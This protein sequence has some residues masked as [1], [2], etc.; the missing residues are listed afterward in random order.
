M[1]IR[2]GARRLRLD[3]SVQR[4]PGLVL[5]GSPISLFRITEAADELIDRIE[6]GESVP[7][8]RLTAALLDGGAVHPVAEPPATAHTI[9]DVTIVVPTLGP[10]EHRPRGDR[11]VIVDDGSVPPIAESTVRLDENRGPAAAR[12]AG[13]EQVHTALVAFVDADVRTP[14][15]WIERLLPHLDD[16]QVAIVA[17]R[18]RS[19]DG[20]SGVARYESSGSALDLGAE[21]GRVRAGNRV[22][23]LPAAALLCRVDALRSVEGFDESLRFGEDVDLVWRLDEAGWRVRYEPAVVVEHEPRA[24]WADWFRQRISYGSSAAPLAIRHRGALAPLRT[25]G[26]SL[27]AWTLPA[28]GRGVAGAGATAAIGGAIA[29]GSAIAL[30]PKLPGVPPSTSVRF[31]LRGHLAAGDNLGQAIRRVYWPIVGVAALAFRP[32]RRALLVAALAA[33]SPLRLA[34]DVAY[35]AGVWRG[36]IEHRTAEPLRP[37]VSSW[38]PRQRASAR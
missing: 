17:P 21:P 34:D 37:R 27:A 10:P 32:A 8:S 2:P 36:M 7:P 24:T 4:F 23:Y 15:G 20:S 35:S 22:G 6:D 13:L 18:V 16:D 28:F 31:A 38:P 11:V 29:V 19:A 26:W 33:R 5:G 30:V 25:N 12:N 3:R 1:P 14:E 9:D